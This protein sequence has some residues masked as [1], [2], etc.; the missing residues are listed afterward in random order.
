M[1]APTDLCRSVQFTVTRADAEPT[2]DGLTLEGYAAVFD[3]PTEIDSWEGCFLEKIRRGAFK[4]TIRETTPVM[5]FDH[6]RHPLIGSIPIGT[7]T[8][9]RED[10]QGLYVA[11]RI[12]D[13]WLM[14]PVRDAIANKSVNGMSFRFSVVRDEWRDNTGTLLKAGELPE[15]LWDPG[16]RGPLERTLIE[17]KMAE[18]GPVVFPAYVGTSVSVRAAG[19]AATIQQDD[20]LRREV[21]AALASARTSHDAPP[22]D[23]ALRREVARAVLFPTT[24]QAAPP[25]GHPADRSPFGHDR[26]A[27][28]ETEP[29]EAPDAPPEGHPSNPEDAPPAEGHP[30][31]TDRAARQLYARRAYVTR[32]GVGKLGINARGE[33]HAAC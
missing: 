20:E 9:L 14:Q 24:S 10:D 28:T 31:P 16:D 29:A 33:E 27:N 4:K 2:G 3:Q 25:E 26:T 11:G 7:I 22:E 23:P 12:S 6:G 18:L 8:D 5:Q 19:I 21:R 15:L 17:L 13:N 32:N 1:N 30:S